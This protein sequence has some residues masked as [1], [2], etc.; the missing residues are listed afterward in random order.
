MSYLGI[1]LGTSG[2][3]VVLIDAV[4]HCIA[5]ASIPLTVS[6]PKDLWS[7]QN[8]EDWW[9]AT[10]NAIDNLK[11][12]NNNELAAVK[13]IGITGQMHGATCIDK[14]NLP[15]RPAILW[16][17]CRS[18][19]ECEVL[20]Q[21][22]ADFKGIN[23]NMVMPGFTAPKLLWLQQHE[24]EI[25][26]QIHK[27]LLPKDYIR[28]QLSGDYASDLSDAAGTSWLDVKNRC[29]SE[30]LLAATNLN[31][32]QMPKVYEG[33]E[34]TGVLLAD[35]AAKWGM[36]SEVKI[37]AGAGDNAAGA[38]SLGIIKENRAMLS[39]GTSGVYFV[40]CASFNPDPS[41]GLHTF[42]HCI[43]NTWHQ[44]GVIL[45]A[46]SCLSWWGEVTGQ[47]DTA[48]LVAKAEQKTLQQVPLFLPYLSGERTPHNDSF[49]KGVFF[50]MTHTTGQA[51][52]IQAVLEGVAFAI[53]DCQNALQEVGTE[54]AE[55]S[56]IGGGAKSKYWGQILASVLNKPLSYHNESELGPAFGA[57]R[58]A[59]IG[60]LA[61]PVGEIASLPKVIDVIHP[62]PRQNEIYM[63]RFGRYRK[64]YQQLK[65]SFEEQ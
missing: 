35:L 7:E 47:Q 42:C 57:A 8:P 51:E 54:V 4:Q 43:P 24:P 36:S 46:A 12:S 58:L 48:K 14:N 22:P 10:C 62:K 19:A 26:K 21:H 64:L 56:I 34:V 45:S 30:Q 1:D 44:M 41:K 49:A 16:N 61:A 6:R 38:I 5:Q 29:W 28:L 18:H 15:L 2:V 50:G 20:N 9:Q 52:F 25:F 3:K 17:D 27:V 55:I 53:A 60:D 65:S 63:E 59:M 39:L 31:L 11:A 37:V 32:E 23:G 13:A 40:P 33:T